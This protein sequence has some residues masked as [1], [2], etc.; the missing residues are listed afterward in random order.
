MWMKKKCDQTPPGRETRQKECTYLAVVHLPHNT[1][2]DRE[3]TYTQCRMPACATPTKAIRNM[4][5]WEYIAHSITHGHMVQ[6][7]SNMLEYSWSYHT[8]SARAL[9]ADALDWWHSKISLGAVLEPSP[10]PS[11]FQFSILFVFSSL[12]LSTSVTLSPSNSS[13]ISLSIY[14]SAV[15]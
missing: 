6:R 15:L 2:K 11:L 1:S 4:T 12:P 5:L 3:H 13:C 10:I 14:L 8:V 9:G 7:S